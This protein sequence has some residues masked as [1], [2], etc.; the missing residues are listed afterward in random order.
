M[1]LDTQAELEVARF[2]G[3]GP[4]PEEIISFHASPEVADRMY[5]LIDQERT[6][7]ITEAEQRELESF[8]YIEHLMR[9][10]KAEAHRKL[11]QHAS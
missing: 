10:V 2:L 8:M 3:S 9:L 11:A 1:V 6:G 7:Q 5:T 4:S